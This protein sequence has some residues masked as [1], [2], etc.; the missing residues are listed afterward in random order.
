[1]RR[2][3]L[4]MVIIITIFWLHPVVAIALAVLFGFLNSYDYYEIVAT[5]VVV[6]IAYQSVFNIGFM[7]IP[8]YT[9]VCII[10]FFTI[11]L[12]K[13]QMNFYA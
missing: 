9:S 5:G 6:D 4:V 12:L 13:K 2:I 3:F 10:L 8:L 1:M 7:S 11:R